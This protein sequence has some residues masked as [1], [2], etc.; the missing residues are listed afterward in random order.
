MIDDVTNGITIE[1]ILDPNFSKEKTAFNLTM[2][3]K[4]QTNM[5]ESLC[6][7]GNIEE[8]GAWKNF[9]MRMKWTEG[10]VWVLENLSIKSKPYFQYKYVLMKDDEPQTWERGENRIA[11]LN[12]LTDMNSTG[13]AALLETLQ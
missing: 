9:K 12:L 3:I 1:S 2:R 13:D 5:G 4:Y 6:V 10:H 7:I 8:F 11:D